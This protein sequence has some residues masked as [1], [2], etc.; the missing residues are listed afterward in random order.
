MAFFRLARSILLQFSGSAIT[1]STHAS[2]DWK[3]F[4]LDSKQMGDY[5]ASAFSTRI[6]ITI[7]D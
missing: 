3:L 4:D 5:A 1:F 2:Y 6:L 7:E